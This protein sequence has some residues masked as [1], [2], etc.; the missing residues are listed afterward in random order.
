MKL[1]V[2]VY[3]PGTD[4][5]ALVESEGDDYYEAKEQLDRMLHSL[6]GKALANPPG[7][8]QWRRPRRV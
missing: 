1:F 3:H 2:T 4:A 7:G 5:A 6:A 8:P